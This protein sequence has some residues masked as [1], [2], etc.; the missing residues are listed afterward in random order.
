MSA[1]LKELGIAVRAYRV[2]AGESVEELADATELS[3]ELLQK[4]EA[5]L[6]KPTIGALE[7]LG[8]HYSLRDSEVRRLLELA[9]HNS[10]DFELDLEQADIDLRKLTSQYDV[11]F[12]PIFY[13]DMVNVV[14]NQYGV[15]INF[16]QN[17][18]GEDKPVVVSR[19]GMSH[20]HAESIIQVLQESVK[21]AKKGQGEQDTSTEE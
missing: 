10:K 12:A 15:T 11:L 3:S 18:N 17:A 2:A 14:S 8:R 1:D 5:G 7:M 6:Q 4:I 19:V 13:T 20:Q 16:I 21:R 9:G